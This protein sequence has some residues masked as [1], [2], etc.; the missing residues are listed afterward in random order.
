MGWFSNPKCPQCGRETTLTTAWDG[1]YYECRYCI[2]KD[3]ERKEKEKIQEQRLRN[4]E[5]RIKELENEK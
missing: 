3:T 4:I 1:D 2:R 5:K